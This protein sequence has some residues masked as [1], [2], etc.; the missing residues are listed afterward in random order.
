[1]SA[2]LENIIMSEA[3]QQVVYVPIFEVAFKHGQWWAIPQDIS[4]LI[5]EQ[6][7]AGHNAGYTWDWGPNGRAGRFTINGER[8]RINRYMI[9]FAAWVQSNLDTQSRRSVRLIWV[10][11]QDVEPIFTGQVTTATVVQPA[12]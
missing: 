11:P 12:Q 6:Y 8:T 3:Q 2:D 5:Y 7:R 4:A 9:D 1:M 10:R